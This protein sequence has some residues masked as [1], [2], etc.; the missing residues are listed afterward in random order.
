MRTD[1]ATSLVPVW[2]KETDSFSI[3]AVYVVSIHKHKDPAA[4]VMI[5]SEAD[6]F[7]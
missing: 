6:N 7:I 1:C 4:V 2:Q 3:Q 5:C